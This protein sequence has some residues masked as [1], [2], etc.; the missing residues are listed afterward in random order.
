MNVADSHCCHDNEFIQRENG[1]RDAVKLFR[2][3]QVK[4]S[5]IFEALKL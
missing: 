5:N 4:I 2:I 1:A 3:W